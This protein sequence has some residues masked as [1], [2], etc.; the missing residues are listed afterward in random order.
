MPRI[1]ATRYCELMGWLYVVKD[2]N[3]IRM[4]CRLSHSVVCRYMRL[5]DGTAFLIAS[6]T[7]A[8]GALT[9]RWN[10]GRS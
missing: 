5:R 2:P 8:L 1:F 6:L 7:L 10:F 3:L 9:L 4:I